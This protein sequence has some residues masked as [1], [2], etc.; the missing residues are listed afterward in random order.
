MV[1]ET[2]TSRDLPVLKAVVELYEA[3][4]SSRSPVT[5]VQKATG[6]DAGKVEQA[7]KVLHTQPYLHGGMKG[8]GAGGLVYRT[9][10][11]PT[12]EGLRAAGAWP[13]PES[14]IERVLAAL[15]S[16]AEDPTRPAEERSKLKQLA[17]GFSGAA[18]QIALNALGGAGGNLLTS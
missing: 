12:A 11:A 9:A 7:L 18:Y 5:A 3:T 13:T 15:T 1:E 10:G 2:W 4:S 14:Q 6:F 17:L 8:R 16:A